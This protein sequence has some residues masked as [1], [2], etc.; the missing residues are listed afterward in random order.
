MGLNAGNSNLNISANANQPQISSS[1]NALGV[2][3]TGVASGNVQGFG[4]ANALDALAF[5][6]LNAALMNK[7]NTDYDELIKNMTNDEKGLFTV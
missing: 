2:N 5:S 3:S 4:G 6:S 1:G 7:P